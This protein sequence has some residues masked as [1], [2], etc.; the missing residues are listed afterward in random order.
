MTIEVN[1]LPDEQKYE[2]VVINPGYMLG[3][4]LHGSSCTSMEV[5]ITLN[6]LF[7]IFHE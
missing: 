6:K 2:L 4:I 5:C 3:P 7:C 1:L